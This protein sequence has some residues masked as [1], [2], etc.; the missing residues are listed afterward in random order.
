T[1]IIFPSC[2]LRG[3]DEVFAA[4]DGGRQRVGGGFAIRG[5]IAGHG[6][7]YHDRRGGQHERG[8]R[9]EERVA[10]AKGKW[11]AETADRDE[12]IGVIRGIEASR[13]CGEVEAG[14]AGGEAETAAVAQAAEA[15]GEAET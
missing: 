13:V 6:Q 8:L 1:G 4:T 11:I 5:R 2:C 12:A 15:R 10:E 9:N 3:D 14:A 7:N